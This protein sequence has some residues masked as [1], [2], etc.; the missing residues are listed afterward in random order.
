MKEKDG[1]D[2]VP[3]EA[4]TASISTSTLISDIS[5]EKSTKISIQLKRSY[6]FSGHPVFFA[7][8]KRTQTQSQSRA[9]ATIDT[10]C[11]IKV[12][13]TSRLGQ[14]P[15]RSNPRVLWSTIMNPPL[16]L[17]AGPTL[18]STA[19]LCGNSRTNSNWLSQS[20]DDDRLAPAGEAFQATRLR[21]K[22]RASSPVSG[23]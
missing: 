8:W 3:A 1:I 17:P 10:F 20:V 4:R 18:C 15:A 6:Q 23:S 14:I 5:A 13:K 16:P 9:R 22:S 7:V 21:P 12:Q 19:I 2:A 11:A